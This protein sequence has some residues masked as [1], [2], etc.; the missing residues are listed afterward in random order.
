MKY[1]ELRQA[2]FEANLMLKA[3][4]LVVLTWGNASAIDRD[5]GLFA[6]KP[7]GVDYRELRAEDMVVLDLETG[8]IADGSKRPSSDTPTHRELYRG[9][10]TIGGIVH[11]HSIH[12][13]AWAQAERAIP[14]YGST[15]ADHWADQIPLVRPLTAKEIEEEYEKAT[16]TAILESFLERGLD[17]LEHPGALLP[18]HGPFTWGRTAM[19][20]ARN[21]VALEAVAQMAALTEQ[22]TPKPQSIP[23]P[24]ADK[25]YSR[26]HGPGAYY[27]QIG[28]KT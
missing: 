8:T 16:G 7:S 11:T 2:A 25:H 24:M 21:A 13:V 5:L 14:V 15:H 9:F 22:I 28:D 19:D 26:K 6:I 3:E 17:P 12:A 27:G 18:H 1:P 10:R 4:G 23:R 20:A